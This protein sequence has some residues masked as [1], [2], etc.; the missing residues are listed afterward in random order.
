MSVGPE[1]K[2]LYMFS[3]IHCSKNLTDGFV[4]EKVGP[5]L[6]RYAGISGYDTARDELLDNGLWETA[7]HG[8][9]V[10]DYLEYNPSKDD[11]LA[12]REERAK[13]GSIGGQRSAAS[14]AQAKAK[15]M[16]EQNSSKTEPN[17]NPVPVPVPVP[18][19]VPIHEERETTASQ[20]RKVRETPEKTK[21]I[22]GIFAAYCRG[23]GIDPQTI[24][25][26]QRSG[27]LKPAAGIL[28]AGYT[29][30]QVEQCTREVKAQPFWQ[31]KRLHLR[32]VADELP[33]W[34]L[35]GKRNGAATRRGPAIDPAP[36]GG[37][38]WDEFNAKYPGPA[39]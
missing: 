5:V 27:Y 1:A 3:I 11:V 29:V 14:K 30:E 18:N 26:D 39:G 34:K 22:Y 10:H 12:L 2:L 38:T 36:S 13:A 16:L 31:D 24:P 9:N 4:A 15:Q 6:A 32:H 35:G 21:Q 33:Q 19:P 28:E 37:Y 23:L 8:Y 17:F 20:S 25:K 7:E